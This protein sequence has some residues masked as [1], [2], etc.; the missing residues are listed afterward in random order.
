MVTTGIPKLPVLCSFSSFVVVMVA[1]WP[2]FREA[3]LEGNASYSIRKKLP[4]VL[5]ELPSWGF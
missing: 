1:T 2:A 5:D 4:Q 3:Q